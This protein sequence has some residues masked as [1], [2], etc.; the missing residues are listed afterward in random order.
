MIKQ[1]QAQVEAKAEPETDPNIGMLKGTIHFESQRDNVPDDEPMRGRVVPD[2]EG[3]LTIYAGI[4]HR[5]DR[6]PETG[7]LVLVTLMDRDGEVS[8]IGPVTDVSTEIE[9]FNNREWK[10]DPEIDS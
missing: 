8:I 3:L 6:L 2:D 7:E 1:A 4:F 5:V 10:P 9:M